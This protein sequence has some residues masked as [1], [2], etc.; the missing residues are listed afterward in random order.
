MRS[1][2][3]LN[4]FRPVAAPGAGSRRGVPSDLDETQQALSAIFQLLRPVERECERLKAAAE[5]EA[6]ARREAADSGVAALLAGAA[7]AAASARA[8]GYALVTEAEETTADEAVAQLSV[9]RLRAS[10][11]ARMSVAVDAIY[12]ELRSQLT[13]LCGHDPLHGQ[14]QSGSTS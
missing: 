4:R 5:G 13:A 2:D 14:D 10:V 1:R 3:W 8:E 6:S 11:S 7:S 12:A 9:A